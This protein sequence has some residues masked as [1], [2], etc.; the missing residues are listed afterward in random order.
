MYPVNVSKNVSAIKRRIYE[1]EFF[2][3]NLP[4]AKSPDDIGETLREGKIRESLDYW[5]SD[6][7]SDIVSD[8]MKEKESI[9]K[10]RLEDPKYKPDLEA[11]KTREDK[12]NRSQYFFVEALVDIQI[13]NAYLVAGKEFHKKSKSE[14]VPDTSI[15]LYKTAAEYL[16]MALDKLDQSKGIPITSFV[17][18]AYVEALNN[19]NYVH[20]ELANAI[21]EKYSR[22]H[23]VEGLLLEGLDPDTVRATRSALI[24]VSDHANAIARNLGRFRDAFKNYLIPSE[25]AIITEM[26][27]KI[28]SFDKAMKVYVEGTTFVPATVSG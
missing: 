5:G 10:L 15:E 24:S 23:S 1:T 11:C 17:K 27:S 21:W 20:T 13:G 9:T 16:G 6:T 28:R 18:P 14:W 12:I 19:L 22:S 3:G 4:K 7:L 25:R 26:R 8:L 2:P